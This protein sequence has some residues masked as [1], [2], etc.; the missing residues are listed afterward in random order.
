MDFTNGTLF[1]EDKDDVLEIQLA[2]IAQA[3]LVIEF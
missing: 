1:L 3:K 2:N